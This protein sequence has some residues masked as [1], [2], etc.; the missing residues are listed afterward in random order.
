[1][2]SLF[3]VM[4]WTNDQLLV[5]GYFSNREDLHTWEELI[6]FWQEDSGPF[7]P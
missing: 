2:K 7:S 5:I 3:H 1:M 4:E 6:A